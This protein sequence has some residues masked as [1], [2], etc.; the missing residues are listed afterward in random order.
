MNLKPLVVVLEDSRKVGFGG[1]QKGSLEVIAA[2]QS[3]FEIVAT[4]SQPDSVFA[5]TSK[6]LL[7]NPVRRLT[8]FGRIKGGN[9]SSFSIGLL[10]LVLYPVLTIVNLIR[11][12]LWMLQWY[13]Q[14]K[15][16]ILYA[17]SKKTLVLAWT[18]K[19]VTRVPVIYHARNFDDNSSLF[20]KPY[21]RILKSCDRILCVSRCVQENLNLPQCELL[22][23][24]VKIHPEQM[25]KS[26]QGKD[27]ICVAVFASL[28]PW[29]GINHFMKAA[30]YLR[31]PQRVKLIVYGTGEEESN[32]KKLVSENTILAGFSHNVE[33]LMKN[34]V[35]I[36]CTPSISEEAFGRVPME[37]YSYGIPA[38]VTNIGAQ[39]EVTLHRVTGIH[40]P[41]SNPEAIANAI[42]E[43]LENPDL[44]ITLSTNALLHVKQFDL[45]HFS[46]SLLSA[47]KST[48]A[49]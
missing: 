18:I 11:I 13:I 21:Y 42:D 35:D 2:L 17:P 10:E 38:I 22:Y 49:R 5:K 45:I 27:S 19:L 6:A 9:S 44:Y 24:A 33:E 34:Q 4:D 46:N 30:Q 16:I 7:G 43:L 41:T 12:L 48:L 37:G 15:T 26:I 36:I 29:K 32:L 25:P 39:A 14:G 23:N 47:F 3:E 28:I 31:Q 8:S 20:Y 40:V 1:G